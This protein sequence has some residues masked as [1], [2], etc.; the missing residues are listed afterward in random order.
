MWPRPRPAHPRG[1]GRPQ[2][3]RRGGAHTAPVPPVHPPQCLAPP[4]SLLTP[5]PL[6][7]PRTGRSR[8]P[9]TPPG[10]PPP[11]NLSVRPSPCAPAPGPGRA[12]D[13]AGGPEPRAQPAAERAAPSA[14]PAPRP[15]PPSLSGRLWGAD[16]PLITT[17]SRGGA[18]RSM[19]AAAYVDH[20]AAE[21]L[22]SMSS[23]AV[24][25][26]PRAGAPPGPEPG[27]EGAVP[28][29]S[30]SV[31]AV[32]AAAEEPRRDGKDRASLFV[33]ARILAD[34]N[35]QPPA[36]PGTGEDRRGDRRREG[37]AGAGA[38]KARTPCRLPPASPPAPR[39]S[40]ER[41]CPAAPP[42]PAWSDPEDLGD[43]QE[44]QEPPE[45]QEAG[46]EPQEPGPRQRGR[47]ARSRA[48]PESPPRRHKCH[49]AGCEKV[50]GKS[51][52]LKAH[53]RT[54][55]GPRAAVTWRFRAFRG[56]HAGGTLPS[57]SS[58]P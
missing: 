51:S 5:S 2:P 43:P 30:T 39:A 55:T 37:G 29:A 25:H 24:V 48:D 49:Y 3:S 17:R 33:V 46:V 22:V 56:G 36:P 50:Y 1:P 9:P 6:G 31:S 11:L 4:P 32:S 16:A 38:R 54:H 44:P 21:C 8:G 40:P 23:R 10:R 26:G 57:A 27:P 15:P 58:R 20:F 41:A 18:A 47:R 7:F 19:A 42:S 52:H 28:A 53:L 35:Q 12:G 34:L 13:G 14:P 45:P